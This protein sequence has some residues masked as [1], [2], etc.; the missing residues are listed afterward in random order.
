MG[1][2]DEKEKIINKMRQALY[3]II[4]YKENLLDIEVVNASKK[5][6]NILNEYNE[7]IEKFK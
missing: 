4:D 7:L 1:N 5:L 2:L 6:D 3:E